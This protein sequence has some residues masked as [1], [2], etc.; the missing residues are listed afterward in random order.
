MLCLH[1][2]SV[3]SAVHASH[4]PEE[5]SSASRVSPSIDFTARRETWK[6]DWKGAHMAPRPPPAQAAKAAV[7]KIF[8]EPL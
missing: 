5:T 7:T 6:R 3:A 2:Q 1:L 8:F 4:S